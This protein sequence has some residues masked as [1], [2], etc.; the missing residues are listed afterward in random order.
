MRYDLWGNPGNNHGLELGF[1]I[2][3]LGLMRSRSWVHWLCFDKYS[4]N[5][6]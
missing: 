5:S 2:L 4:P 1:E 6:I 3:S